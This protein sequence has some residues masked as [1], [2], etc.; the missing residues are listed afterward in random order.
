VHQSAN[1]SSRGEEC[2]VEDHSHLRIEQLYMGPVVGLSAG[3]QRGKAGE[4]G[5][6][7]AKEMESDVDEM[8]AE[9][10]PE[11]GAG[12]GVFAP[13]LTDERTEAVLVSF[14]VC[15]SAEA[16]GCENGFRCED[17]ALPAAVLKDGQEPVVLAR[18][19]DELT[20]FSEIE[21]ERFVDDDMLSRPKRGGGKREVAVVRTGDDDQVHVRMCGCFHERADSHVWE[22]REHVVGS[23]GADN[24]ELKSRN[25]TDERSVKGFADVAVA[26]EADANRSR[27]RRGCHESAFPE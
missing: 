21:G 5:I 10:V 9:I 11:S 2:G 18:N 4:N 22:I 1:G 8:G 19:L 15:D 13:A 12:T 6:G 25:R 7:Q 20:S 26:D 17:V 14:K 16:A 3:A 27:G 24:G 23:A